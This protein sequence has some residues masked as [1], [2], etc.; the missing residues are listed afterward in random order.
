MEQP[1][2]GSLA[3][4]DRKHIDKYN[5]LLK[6][7]L[8]R[9]RRLQQ[10]YE[11]R[12][13]KLPP[14]SIEPLSHE[15][16]RLSGSGMT[17]EQRAARLQWVKDQELAPNEPRNIPELF[18]KNPIRRAM[19]APWD[20]IFNALK[21]II[22]NK[23]AFTGRIVVPRIALYGFFFYAAYYHIKYNRNSWTGRQ[24]WHLWGKKEMVLPGDPRWPNG[25]EKEHDDFFN[26]GFKERK[27]FNQ[28][29]TSFTE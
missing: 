15:R 16:D 22:G 20:M 8:E 9:E 28:I 13:N 24:G 1:P 7:S 27:V 21:P 4:I 25:L 6:E 5:R 14:F 12:G 19:A 18:P 29:K 2:P 17:P 23:A 3:D 10:H 11:W 26:K